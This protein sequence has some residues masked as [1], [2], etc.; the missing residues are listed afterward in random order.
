M[1]RNTTNSELNSYRNSNNAPAAEVNEQKQQQ[2][3]RENLQYTRYVAPQNF[4]EVVDEQDKNRG[5]LPRVMRSWAKMQME[6]IQ[7]AEIEG[8]I[9][10]NKGNV[11][12]KAFAGQN[13]YKAATAAN[14][15]SSSV[16]GESKYI[17]R[18]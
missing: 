16:W 1:Q 5:K 7:K 6:I 4:A 18:V 14:S 10:T 2:R 11:V 15:T 3:L 8:G 17:R 12:N 9:G 13:N